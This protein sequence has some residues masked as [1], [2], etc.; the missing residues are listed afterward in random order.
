MNT[1][2]ANAKGEKLDFFLT[3]SNHQNHKPKTTTASTT[4]P[5]PIIKLKPKP[6]PK[7]H[8]KSL[9]KTHPSLSDDH[10]PNGP[11]SLVSNPTKNTNQT[12][13]RM[14]PKNANSRTPWKLQFWDENEEQMGF[15]RGFLGSIIERR[16]EPGLRE[17]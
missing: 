3:T 8:H 12:N 4:W 6:P 11:T 13:S 14:M 9:A 1:N 10:H 15:K 5:P 2:W 7:T 16:E 17:N